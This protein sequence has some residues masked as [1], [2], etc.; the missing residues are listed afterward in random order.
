MSEVRPDGVYTVRELTAGIACLLQEAVVACDVKGTME[1]MV[2]IVAAL[3]G[4]A[5]VDKVAGDVKVTGMDIITASVPDEWGMTQGVT[6]Y[7][8]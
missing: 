3:T 5:A 7:D 2:D 4:L 8:G 1:M 6:P